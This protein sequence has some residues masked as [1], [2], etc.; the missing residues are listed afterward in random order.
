M[1]RWEW[2]RY[3][4]VIQDNNTGDCTV[5]ILKKESGEEGE[6]LEEVDRQKNKSKTIRKA[7]ERKWT[8]RRTR[9]ATARQ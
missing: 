3:T 4:V 6:E 5:H 7:A 9:R 8:D 2:L 1:E